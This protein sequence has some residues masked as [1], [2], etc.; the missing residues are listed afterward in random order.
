[1]VVMVVVRQD[2]RELAGGGESGV[3]AAVV[4]ARQRGK[5]SEMEVVSDAEER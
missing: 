2:D 3:W 1:M 4:A 5:G